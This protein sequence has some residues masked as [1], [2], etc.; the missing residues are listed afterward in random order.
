MA[1]G[2]TGQVATT[3]LPLTFFYEFVFI[4]KNHPVPTR[5]RQT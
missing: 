3:T 1:G 2:T 4:K 5:M